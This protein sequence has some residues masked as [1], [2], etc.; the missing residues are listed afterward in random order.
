M[1]LCYYSLDMPIGNT[2]SCLP[3][4]V[5]VFLRSLRKPSTQSVCVGFIPECIY[6]SNHLQI[7]LQMYR[8]I[9]SMRLKGYKE[10]SIEPND[11]YYK[12]TQATSS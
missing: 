2:Q 5:C 8:A 10:L 3:G 9:H 6:T 7:D 1:H 4:Q 12:I 11:T